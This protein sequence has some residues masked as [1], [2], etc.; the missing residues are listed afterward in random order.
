[1][2]YRFEFVNY[3]IKLLTTTM[4]NMYDTI[5]YIINDDDDFMDNIVMEPEPV[6]VSIKGAGAGD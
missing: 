2:D 4:D 3:L 6:Y 5:D 1:M